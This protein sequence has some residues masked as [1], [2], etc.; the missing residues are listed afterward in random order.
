M[1]SIRLLRRSLSLVVALTAPALF[2]A[3]GKNCGCDCCKDRPKGVACCC[4]EPAATPAAT[5]KADDGIKRYPLKGVIMSVR[6]DLSGLSVKHE[7]IPGVMRAMTM[8]FKVDAAT[9]KVAQKGQVI[10]GLMSRRGNEWVLEDVK[11]VG[12]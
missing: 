10:T 12:K 4:N 7:E 5:A 11:F 1:N 6:A 3:E 8:M 2:A 9:L